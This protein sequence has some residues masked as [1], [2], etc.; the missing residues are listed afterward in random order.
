MQIEFAEPGAGSAQFDLQASSTLVCW[1]C[2]REWIGLACFVN[3]CEPRHYEHHDP[4]DE[5]R[6]ER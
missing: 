6:S 1:R 2:K 3:A 5:D 4:G